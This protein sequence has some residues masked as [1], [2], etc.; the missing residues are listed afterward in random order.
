MKYDGYQRGLTS[1]VFKFFY[2]K[3]S[4]SHI[5]NGNMWNKELT[6]ELRKQI[7]R[8]FEKRKVRSSFIDNIWGDDIADI[9][10]ISKF[11]TLFRFLLCV[12]DN[13]SKYAW[14]I[15]LKD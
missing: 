11:N 6:E 10:L 14:V 8:K 1:M 4:C 2:K 13:F 15:P 12:I 3:Y 7:I 5:K 9:Q